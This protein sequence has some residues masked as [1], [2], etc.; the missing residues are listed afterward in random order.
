M[1]AFPTEF[2]ALFCWVFRSNNKINHYDEEHVAVPGALIETLCAQK[3]KNNS[4]QDV[5]IITE[6]NPGRIAADVSFPFCG[7]PKLT[8]FYKSELTN[9]II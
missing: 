4:Q 8:V 7:T 1:D 2:T 6:F 3:E 9:R 5:K